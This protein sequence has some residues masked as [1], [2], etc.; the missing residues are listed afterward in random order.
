ML[1]HMPLCASSAAGLLQRVAELEAAGEKE[2]VRRQEVEA[3]L[4]EATSAF[5]RDLADKS[6]EIRYVVGLP[7]GRGP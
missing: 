4:Q 1:L 3:A 5:K 6:Q 2:H 7:S